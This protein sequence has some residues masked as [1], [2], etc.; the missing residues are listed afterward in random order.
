MTLFIDECPV[1][2]RGHGMYM[3]GRCKCHNGWKGYYHVL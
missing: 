3:N 1:L 2:C